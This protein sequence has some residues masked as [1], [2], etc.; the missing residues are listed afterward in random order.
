MLF[1]SM[2]LAEFCKHVDVLVAD[3]RA[4]KR[5]PG[6]ERIRMPGEGSFNAL[7]ENSKQG[8]MMPPALLEALANLAAEL[9]IAPLL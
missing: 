5:M 7:N 3:L 2:P 6:A 1:R 8:V 9:K 4:S